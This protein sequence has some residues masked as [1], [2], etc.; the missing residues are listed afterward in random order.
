MKKKLLIRLQAAAFDLAVRALRATGCW[1]AARPGGTVG[2]P[3]LAEADPLVLLAAVAWAGCCPLGPRRLT[4][5]QELFSR[6]GRKSRTNHEGSRDFLGLMAD[7][8]S[9]LLSFD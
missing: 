2:W 3:G 1:L 7:W 5:P 8:L 4:A 6:R 9:S